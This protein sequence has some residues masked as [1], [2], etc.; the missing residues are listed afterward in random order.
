[1]SWV[2]GKYHRELFPELLGVGGS[3]CFLQVHG[4]DVLDVSVGDLSEHECGETLAMELDHHAKFGPI[5]AFA[6]DT[7]PP[8]LTA[9][10]VLKTASPLFLRA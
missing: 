6:A 1:M 5:F 9:F 4:T 2:H 3:E 8:L 7:I 10:K